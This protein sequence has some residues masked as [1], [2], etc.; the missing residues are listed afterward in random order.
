M[1]GGIVAVAYGPQIVKLAKDIIKAT[2]SA[3]DPYNQFLKDLKACTERFV[4]GPERDE[5]YKQAADKFR[6]A[7]G[8]GP[9]N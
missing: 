5:C 2:G 8:R 6:R 1:V 3:I 4:P 7:T 9:I